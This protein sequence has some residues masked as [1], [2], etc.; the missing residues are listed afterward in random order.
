MKKNIVDSVSEGGR[1]L[2]FIP[3]YLLKI[4]SWFGLVGTTGL[5]GYLSSSPDPVSEF[6]TF[7][8]S[9]AII[10]RKDDDSRKNETGHWWLVCNASTD[11]L[12][13]VMRGV[14]IFL[15]GENLDYPNHWSCIADQLFVP[16]NKTQ[17][18]EL[19]FNGLKFLDGILTVR[20]DSNHADW[21]RIVNYMHLMFVSG[22]FEEKSH[23]VITINL[24]LLRSI[25][26][27]S[28]E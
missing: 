16:M 10:W 7:V 2:S 23:D 8:G 6:E 1:S 21:R 25:Q 12:H 18:E 24:N 5:S 27:L 17:K 3:Q 14:D 4:G 11:G 13:H 20:V 19:R 9:L 15:N 26:P 22:I 28:R